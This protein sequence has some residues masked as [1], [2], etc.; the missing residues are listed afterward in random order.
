MS[1][2]T[3]D[4]PF[5]IAI[6]TR[7]RAD[8]IHRNPLWQL[9]IA[10]VISGEEADAYIAAGMPKENVVVCG[11]YP[12]IATKRQWILDNLWEKDEPCIVQ[13]D[14]DFLG[15]KPTMTWRSKLY[16]EPDDLAA[17]FWESSVSAID[18]GA[19][20][21][22]YMRNANPRL[23]NCN[24][25]FTLRRWIHCAFGVC[26]R[27]V[28]FDPRLYESE[29]IDLSLLGLK[30][31]RI[32]WKD[33][34]FGMK[35]IPSRRAG[36]M[37]ATITQDRGARSVSMINSKHGEEIVQIVRDAENSYNDGYQMKVNVK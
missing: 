31:N 3:P 14:D 4:L 26:D 37:A 1:L 6:P 34:R 27:A 17:I 28:H 23:R 22:G 21:F 30:L 25:P 8:S 10:V 12:N 29:D 11:P 18:A 13:V 33:N 7:S 15:L 20:I 35:Y 9:G 2:T 5:K 24:A 19:G 32:I 16:E 36:G